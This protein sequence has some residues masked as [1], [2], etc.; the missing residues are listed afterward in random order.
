M[1]SKGVCRVVVQHIS[2]EMTKRVTRACFPA[3]TSLTTKLALGPA[4][5]ARNL[6]TIVATLLNLSLPS[7]R[8]RTHP[9]TIFE[10]GGA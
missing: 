5:T 8:L 7:I 4:S 10:L 3:S 9:A 6:N 1:R 2:C